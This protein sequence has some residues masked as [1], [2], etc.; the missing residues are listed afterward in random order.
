MALVTAI[1]YDLDRNLGRAY[2]DIM[3]RL[4]PGDWCCFLDHD[5]TWTTVEWYRQLLEAIAKYP[6]AGIFAAVTNR[7]GR[8]TQIPQSAP[9]GHDMRDHRAFGKALFE[10]YGST[11]KDITQE[12]PISGVVMCLSRETWGKIRGFRSG[13]FGV[14]NYAHIDVRSAGLKVYLMPGLYVQH[15][16]RGDG[17]GH[18]NAPRAS[19]KR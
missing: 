8:K 13:F 15:W 12:S 6:D 7:I 11:A 19:A 2:N 10:K 4:F 5:A 18:K 17:V 3:V 9:A 14:D 1:A 16:Y